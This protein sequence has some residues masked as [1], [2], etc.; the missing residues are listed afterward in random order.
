MG[1]IIIS[2][3]VVPLGQKTTKRTITKKKKPAEQDMK[4]ILDSLLKQGVNFFLVE[5]K[6]VCRIGAMNGTK[7]VGHEI[8]TC[9]HF[10][11]SS[12]IS[13]VKRCSQ[14]ETLNLNN[15]C[16]I[17]CRA[18]KLGTY[19]EVMEFTAVLINFQ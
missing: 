14:V 11:D 2:M 6:L 4:Q 17:N 10:C 19:E 9:E 16:C 13:W 12:M 18:F 7:L 8:S 15:F 1:L 3:S 5:N